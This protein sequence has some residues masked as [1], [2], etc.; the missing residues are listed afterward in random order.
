MSQLV[1]SS[2]VLAGHLA[3]TKFNLPQSTSMPSDGAVPQLAQ[4]ELVTVLVP[5][6]ST[7]YSFESVALSLSDSRHAM[8]SI[9]LFPSLARCVSSFLPL[10]RFYFLSN[11]AAIHPRIM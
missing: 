8:L 11:L 3:C 10:L 1:F 5:I 6:F 2:N 7:S 9:L 4:H